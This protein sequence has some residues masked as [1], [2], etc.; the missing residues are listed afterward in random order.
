[1]R[2]ALLQLAGWLLGRFGLST[3]VLSIA[4]WVLLPRWLDPSLTLAAAV[5]A[6]AAVVV[7]V[8]ASWWDDRTAPDTPSFARPRKGADAS[9]LREDPN[10]SVLSDRGGYLFGRR[11][12]FVGT[13]CPPLRLRSSFAAQASERQRTEP[14]QVAATET[15]TY[16]WFEDRFCWENQGLESRDVMALLRERDRRRRRGLDRAHLSLGVDDA[17]ERRRAPIPEAVRRAVFERDAG[18]CVE[19][20]S[21][22]GIQYDHVIPWSMGGADTVDNLQILCTTCNQSKGATV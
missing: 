1:M 17:G 22:F 13:G 8:L 10:G 20:G 19:C 2:S 9:T 11:H 14:V 12:W 5:P 15:R 18:R 7:G 3:V 21:T 6:G 16:W 4:G